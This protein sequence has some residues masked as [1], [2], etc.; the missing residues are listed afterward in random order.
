MLKREAAGN[1]YNWSC[2]GKR[3]ME[4]VARWS[5]MIKYEML[6]IIVEYIN[7]IIVQIHKN[8]G[9]S[10]VSKKERNSR[11]SE[12]NRKMGKCEEEK[13]MLVGG[14]KK[15]NVFYVV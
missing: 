12:A 2:N 5:D 10:G 8:I 4:R 13:L 15:E 11:Q 9:Q 7:I 1:W 14:G 3:L 6:N